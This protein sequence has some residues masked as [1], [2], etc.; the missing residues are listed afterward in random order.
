MLAE[1]SH[2][3]KLLEL[4]N[5]DLGRAQLLDLAVRCPERLDHVVLLLL[6]LVILKLVWHE[7]S[8]HER[9]P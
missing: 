9:L 7:E 5:R 3:V 4:Y 6:L 8:L 1:T 2:G